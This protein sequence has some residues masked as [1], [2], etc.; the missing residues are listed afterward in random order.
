MVISVSR[1]VT[2]LAAAIFA[3]SFAVSAQAGHDYEEPVDFVSQ[4]QV[5]KLIDIGEEVT[6]IDLRSAEN[7]AKGHLPNAKS[8]PVETLG[9]RWKE[10]PRTGRVVLYCACPPDGRDETFA[11]TLMRQ[12][13]YRNVTVLETGYTGWVKRGYPVEAAS[14]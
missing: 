2:A 8:I 4:E 7:F 1:Y 12:E 3:V 9:Q 14:R 5:K 13:K 10:I 6:F 11:F